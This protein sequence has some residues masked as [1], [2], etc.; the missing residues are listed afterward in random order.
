MATQASYINI[1]GVAFTVHFR[2]FDVPLSVQTSAGAAIELLPMHFSDYLS[3]LGQCMYPHSGEIKLNSGRLAREFLLHSN[4]HDDLHRELSPVALWWAIGGENQ[5]LEITDDAVNLGKH[6]C[7]LRSWTAKERMQAL[8]KCLTEPVS[9]GN[10]MDFD[11]IQYVELMIRA[12]VVN[13]RPSIE[14]NA[15]DAAST[16]KLLEAVTRLNV[17]ESIADEIATW[18]SIPG[19]QQMLHS[20]LRLCKVLG[21]G[22]SQVW[23]L[24]AA[25]IDRL[26]AM[27]EL[28]N[29]TQAKPASHSS[30][31]ISD[32]DA[33]VINI[34]DDHG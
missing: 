11:F 12:S 20:T 2:G 19:L 15:V 34:E 4:I 8:A 9:N 33:V 10:G 26:L 29:T 24:P 1:D 25:E 5:P 28:M 32:P 22:P 18:G 14:I 27:V 16:L 6:K 3:V 30:R 7:Q 31:F 17:A 23:S 21:W 13:I